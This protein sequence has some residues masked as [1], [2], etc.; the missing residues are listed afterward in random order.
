MT[1]TLAEH[2]G[3]QELPVVEGELIPDASFALSEALA[4]AQAA[5]REARHLGLPAPL[6]ITAT[7]AGVHASA[8][9]DDVLELQ[10]I[11][12]RRR[13]TSARGD[14]DRGLV[15]IEGEYDGQRWTLTSMQHRRITGGTR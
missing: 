7:A 1:A 2:A 13:I 15:R 10:T 5:L 3:T 8:P 9:L 6:G 14:H 4:S 12:D 11:L